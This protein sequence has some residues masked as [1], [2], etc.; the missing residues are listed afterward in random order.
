[1]LAACAAPS[2]PPGAA[3]AARAIP[4]DLSCAL[5]SNCVSTL[6]AGGAVPL[7]YS[8]TP[9]QALAAL[10]ATLKTFPEATESRREGLSIEAIFTTPLGF[11]DQVEFRI[12]TQSQHIDYRSRSLFGLYDWGKNRARMMEFKQR[13]DKLAPG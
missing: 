3:D 2:I 7:R 9:E 12:D 10:R 13:F 8:G 4:A 5:P 1:M 6:G 11:R